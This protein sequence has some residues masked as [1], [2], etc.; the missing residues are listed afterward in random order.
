MNEDSVDWTR[1]GYGFYTP[2]SLVARS[3]TI[4]YSLVGIP[5]FLVYLSIVGERVAR[6]IQTWRCCPSCLCCRK[7]HQHNRRPPTYGAYSDVAM[8]L[9][10]FTALQPR[11][12]NGHAG[13]INEEAAYDDPPVAAGPL[14]RPPSTT[15]GCVQLN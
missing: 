12:A 13:R 2:T 8:P 10:S 1:A 3:L 6:V 5:L 15:R 9:E 14:P 4:M 11:S 7:S